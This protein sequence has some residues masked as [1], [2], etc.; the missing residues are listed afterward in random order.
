MAEVLHN[1]TRDT[2]SLLSVKNFLILEK[3]SQSPR[4]DGRPETPPEHAL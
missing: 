4:T 1:I 3:K 2:F